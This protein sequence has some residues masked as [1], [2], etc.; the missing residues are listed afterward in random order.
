MNQKHKTLIGILVSITIFIPMVACADGGIH[1]S[2]ETPQSE[3]QIN[4]P[5]QK[6]I[7][8]WDDYYKKEVILLSTEI[9]TGEISDLAW[10]IP[11]PSKTKPEIEEA[12]IEIFDT[13]PWLFSDIKRISRG[14]GGIIG[15]IILAIIVP[16]LL[17]WLL[18]K[19]RTK[20]ELISGAIGILIIMFFISIIFVSLGGARSGRNSEVLPIEIIET[21]KVGIYD[22]MILKSTDANFM[23]DWLNKNGYKVSS[24]ST[25]ILQEYCSQPNS[26][27][28]VNRIN[29]DALDEKDL[30][31]GIATPLEIKF[32]PEKPFYPMKLS[33]I[34]GGE[35][36]IDIYFFSS[37][38][39]GDESGL[40][41]VKKSRNI[42][43]VGEAI[44]FSRNEDARKAFD[45]LQN[46]PGDIDYDF[47]FM[48]SNVGTWLQYEG[49]LSNLQKDSYFSFEALKCDD[50]PG[51]EADWL[52]FE[53]TS[54]RCYEMF[55]KERKDISFCEKAT[56]SS[57]KDDCYN[58]FADTN[59]DPSLCEKISN[60]SDRYSCYVD[61]AKKVQKAS[62]C[63]EKPISQLAKDICYR[64]FSSTGKD[65]ALCEKI[66]NREEKEWCYRNVA[67]ATEDTSLCEK[68][69]FDRFGKDKCYWDIAIKKSDGSLCE[70]VSGEWRNS[71]YR[72]IATQ[73]NNVS[74][75]EKI[76]DK[77]TRENG[78]YYH[79]AVSTKDKSLCDRITNERR[80]E[81]C[82]ESIKF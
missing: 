44:R 57:V 12:E 46:W 63:E 27:F 20:L 16:I 13:V 15:I 74:L 51:E 67:V 10:V 36:L 45:Y 17:F 8:F 73:T 54:S 41:K 23:V 42:R 19:K 37:E 9:K 40:L 11:V 3:D 32:Q 22:V 34:N 68:I 64:V 77:D 38:P 71:C 39:V 55:A 1:Y 35:T 4:I 33:S 21:K 47:P 28:I 43:A 29:K 60:K 62:T 79:I 56:D 58:Y 76:T 65:S 52:D 81:S 24:K 49:N 72:D 69:R 2:I 50:L 48:F 80:R 6:A 5:H 14:G 53:I 31:E 75:C 59:D 82:Y 7:I 25:T 61:F 18:R 70:K 78:C 66:N 30:S 26:Y